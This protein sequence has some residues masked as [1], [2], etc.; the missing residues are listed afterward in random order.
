MRARLSGFIDSFWPDRNG[1]AQ[2]R[3]S[4]GDRGL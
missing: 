1:R 4:N 2:R 3:T